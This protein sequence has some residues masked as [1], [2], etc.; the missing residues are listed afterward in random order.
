M[1]LQEYFV[2]GGPVMYPLLLCSIVGLGF[3]IERFLHYHRAT[4]DTPGFL[5][6]MRKVVRK[7]KIKEAIKICEGYRGPIASILKAALLRSSRGREEIEKALQF[8]GGLELSRLERG[9][10]VLVTISSIAPLLGFLGTVTGMINSFEA[11]ADQGLN[12]PTLVARGISEAL[13]TTATG[14]CIAIPVLAFY[15]YFTSRVSKLVIEME[16]SA[17]LMLELLTEDDEDGDPSV[18]AV[19]A[20]IE[21][22]PQF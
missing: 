17:A 2:K 19:D 3:I 15:N 10:V 18:E 7:G 21:R 6:K 4:I 1:G 14:L 13:I 11:M 8:S 12:N 22:T 9:L 20:A 5:D 16:E